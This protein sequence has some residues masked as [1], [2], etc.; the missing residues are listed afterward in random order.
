[1]LYRRLSVAARTRLA[2]AAVLPRCAVEA[3][4]S[5][6][7]V[8]ALVKP[9]GLRRLFHAHVMHCTSSTSESSSASS[10]SAAEASTSG[11]FTATTPTTEYCILNF[12]HLV[13]IAAP[14]S[15]VEE[16]RQW[17]EANKAEVRG[18]IYISHQGINAQMGGVTEDAKA[19]VQWISSQPYFKVS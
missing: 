3:K 7:C 14:K 19:Y 5:C 18:R 2:A 6:L 16:Q 13:D 12:Y 10:P 11:S 9:L 17:I 4:P 1:M 8:Q 15:V